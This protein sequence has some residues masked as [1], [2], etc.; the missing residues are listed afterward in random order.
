MENII[1]LNGRIAIVDD[2]IEQALPLMRVLS[3]NNIPYVFYQGNNVDFLP[4]ESENDIRILFLDLNL[5]GGRDAN[6]KEIRS[7]LFNTIK[8]I[9]SPNNYP[10]VLILWSRQENEYKEMLEELFSNELKQCAPITIQNFIKS[11]FFPNFSEIEENEEKEYLILDELKKIILALPAYSY[12][13]QWENC[14]HNSADATI[15]DLFHD[16]HSLENWRNNANCILSMF[17][18]SYLEKKYEISSPQEKAK[19][20]LLFLNDVYNDTLESNVSNVLFTNAVD[21]SC[22]VPDDY[23]ND[24][25]AKINGCI[26]FSNEFESVHQPGCVFC[27]NQTE[28]TIKYFHEIFNSSFC[29]NGLANKDA[30]LMKQEIYKSLQ[31]CEIVVTPA[32]DYAQNKMKY[33]RIVHGVI[34][35][36]EY[37]PYI[38]FKSE[39]I[40]ISPIFEFESRKRIIVL[41]FRYFVTNRIND[42]EAKILFRVRTSLLAEIQSKLARHINRQGIMNL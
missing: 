10:Y 24:I 29:R 6:P 22:E 9:I 42:I 2:V 25:I 37:R 35:D 34:I 31:P 16:Y 41:N 39:A 8:K 33:D 26:L 21:L 20:S 40:Y 3:K 30:K 23:R 32:C 15:Q 4:E 19:A 13:M 1:P 7:V 27:V 36:A 28:T 11:D 12:L 17:A 5:L 38:D 14:V 18:N